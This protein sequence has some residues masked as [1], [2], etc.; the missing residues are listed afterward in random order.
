MLDFY[1]FIKQ[2]AGTVFAAICVATFALPI[3][4]DP[5]QINS[6][7]YKYS[8]TIKFPGYSGSTPLTD[9]PVLIRLSTARNAF[10][11]AKCPN[12]GNLRFAD[13][14]GNLLAHEID[15]WNE[16]GESLVWVKVPSLDSSTVITAYYG[17]TGS[18]NPP[19]VTAS[20]VWSNGYV[21]VWH[22]GET[23]LDFPDSTV[24]G[25]DFA[26]QQ[27]HADYVGRGIEN[28]AVGKSVEFGVNGSTAGCLLADDSD[29][30]D[31]FQA[32][33]F[34]YWTYQTTHAP[35]RN[36][37]LFKKQGSENTAYRFYENNNDPR[38]IVGFF[39][40]GYEDTW[41]AN[42]A[43]GS[44]TIPVDQWNHQAYTYNRQHNDTQSKSFG[45]L[46]G[47]QISSRASTDAHY[48]FLSNDGKLCL[49]NEKAAG[50]NA[51]AGRMDEFRISNVARSAEWLKA[52]FDTVNND[53]FALY[54]VPNDWEKYTH[55]FSVSFPGAT[56]GVL[57]AF[58]V[59]VKVSEYDDTT[60]TGI[61]GFSYAD[62]L[63]PNGGDL[64]FSDADG[65]LLASEVD[66]WNPAG[67]SLIWVNVPTLSSDTK[68]TAYY[69]WEFAS[70]VDSMNVWSNGYVGVWHLGESSSP[71]GVSTLGASDFT[72]FTA[73]GGRDTTAGI[74]YAQTGIVGGAAKFGPSEIYTNSCLRAD[75]RDAYEGMDAITVEAWTCRDTDTVR[76][77]YVIDMVAN[78]GKNYA[79]RMSDYERSGT[80]RVRFEA[81]TTDDEGSSSISMYTSGAVSANIWYHQVFTYDSKSEVANNALLYIN[82]KLDKSAAG[83]N[84]PV[85]ATGS[86]GILY[87]G[88]QQGYFKYTTPF[89]GKI[90][91]VR[92]SNVARSAGWL[93]TTYDMIQGNAAFAKYSSARKLAGQFIVIIR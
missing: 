45:Y 37:T 13:A 76:N 34:E 53:E 87:L 39:L 29:L 74:Y 8:F 31:G 72:T 61:R 77:G 54:I 64:R 28:G 84:K 50:S 9:F 59:L 58:P 60:G 79:W 24:N 22:L 51:Y 56:N 7:D 67:E 16:S 18:G 78:T 83:G 25:L 89:P 43:K 33:T 10:D 88:N 21:G 70:A 71:L 44:G 46:N 35:D 82:G 15:T 93:A 2:M 68:V 23:G 73:G 81:T 90:D 80:A 38:T 30:L 5:V 20:D 40:D 91:E 65:N 49:G 19:A 66:T 1:K 27:N 55:M 26:C 12:G 85:K 75:H 11:Y 14:N 4:A 41:W 36:I 69:G 6:D 52:T 63:K 92:I 62:C 48:T 57:S 42:A 86:E 17:Y 32:V 3:F 47:H